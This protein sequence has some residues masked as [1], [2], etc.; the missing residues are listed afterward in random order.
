MALTKVRDA[1][2]PAGAVLQVKTAVKTDKESFSGSS[3]ADITG[4]SVSITPISTSSKVVVLVN[5]CYGIASSERIMFTARRGS[6]N[7]VNHSSTLSNRTPAFVGGTPDSTNDVHN[8]SF[9]CLD[10]PSTTSATTYKVQATTSGGT[11]YLNAS[12]SDSDSA[13][14]PRGISSITVMEI[15]G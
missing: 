15:A 7:L 9:M 6:T 13:G 14:V 2:M 3:Y 5:V 8:A 11:H 12:Y 4:L 10:S 1:V